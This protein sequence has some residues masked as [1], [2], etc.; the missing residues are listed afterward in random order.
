MTLPLRRL[1][2]TVTPSTTASTIAASFLST[3]KTSRPLIRSQYLDANQLQRLGATLPYSTIYNQDN[4]PI[5]PCHHL[6]YFTPE[7]VESELG[8]DGS[9][10]VF[11]PPGPFTRRMWAGGELEWVRDNQLM[12]GQEVEEKTVLQSVEAKMTRA[13][14]EMVVVGVEKRFENAKGLAIIDRRQVIRTIL[15]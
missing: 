15:S 9:D 12:A 1:Y 3:H 14:E 6:V 4:T 10:R 5:P 2:S 8:A 11:N 7:V 13:G